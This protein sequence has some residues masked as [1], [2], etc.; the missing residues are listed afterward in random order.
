[1]WSFWYIFPVLV[2][3][4]KEKSGNPGQQP[5][6][7]RPFSKDEVR[8]SK[9]LTPKSVKK[10][11]GWLQ[12]FWELVE[13][14]KNRLDRNSSLKRGIRTHP[15]AQKMLFIRTESGDRGPR[16]ARWFIFKPKFG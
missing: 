1:L 6:Y 11:D 12:K 14:Q 5:S 13:Q 16:V 2:F 9:S 4:T 15:C 3:C 7:F 8:A 10:C